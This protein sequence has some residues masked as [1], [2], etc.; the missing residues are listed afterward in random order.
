MTSAP[1]VAP[2][3]SPG[4]GSPRCRRFDGEGQ[5]AQQPAP[6]RGR[7]DRFGDAD[8]DIDHIAR[9]QLLRGACADDLMREVRRLLP[10]LARQPQAAHP[11]VHMGGR[12]VDVPREGWVVVGLDDL[13]LVG[14]DDHRVDEHPRH[15]DVARPGEDG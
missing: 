13:V 2:K 8:A 14:T 4:A 9:P 5:G 12:H 6:R 1:I 3:A 11:V 15:D 7:A 10:P